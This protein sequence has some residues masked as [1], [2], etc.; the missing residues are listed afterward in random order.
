MFGVVPKQLWSQHVPA[1]ELN[2]CTWSMRLLLIESGNR[3]LLIDTGI[4]DKQSFKFFS[5]YH[6][7]GDFTL[8]GELEK[9][10]F[11]RDDITDVLLTHLHFDHVGGAVKRMEDGALIPAFPNATFWSCE[12]HWDWATAPNPREKASFLAENILPLESSGNLKF[13]PREGRWSRGPSGQH[14]PDLD[15]F[16]ADGHTESQM[17]PVINWRGTRVAYMADLLPSSAHVPL[18][19]VIGY[20]TRPLLTMEEKALFLQA[21]ADE[22]WV[23]FFEHDGQHA[24]CTV[25]HTEKG[26][27]VDERATTLEELLDQH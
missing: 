18:A 8:D 13:I 21:A 15:I 12:K 9:R 6:L 7:H 19:W 26:V 23:L 17:I 2:L 5:H 4:G 10:G 20:D 27:R 1:D 16:F 3:L 22:G 14:F 11:H 24:A 25:R